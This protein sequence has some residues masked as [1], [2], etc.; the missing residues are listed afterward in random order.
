M[1]LSKLKTATAVLVV[2]AAIGVGFGQISD[3]PLAS[4]QDRPQI[5]GR[6]LRPAGFEPIERPRP[7]PADEKALKKAACDG[8]YRILLKKIEVKSDRESYQDFYEYGEWTGN[9]YAEHDN[10]PAGWWVYVYPHWYIWKENRDATSG[11]EKKATVDGRYSIL[12]RKIEVKEDAK[13]FGDFHDSGY[14]PG[15]KWANHTDLPPGYWVY[16]APNWYIWGAVK[17]EPSKA[18][19]RLLDAG[20]KDLAVEAPNK[21]NEAENASVKGKYS[22]LLKV[23]EVPTDKDAYGEFNDYGYSPTQTY[24]GHSNIPAGYWVYVA[25]NWYIWGESKEK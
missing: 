6:G 10:L 18:R 12:L 25:P 13:T 16:V 2:A 15:D 7:N 3:A 22:R 14:W 20:S 11:D 19:R 23:I 21:K 8:K 17:D 4:A 24:A 5:S 9:S 1:F